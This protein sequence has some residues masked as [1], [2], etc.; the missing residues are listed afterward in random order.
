MSGTLESMRAS[1]PVESSATVPDEVL[2]AEIDRTP[3]VRLRE[4]SEA[5][6]MFKLLGMNRAA[7]HPPSVKLANTPVRPMYKSVQVTVVH[8]DRPTV[9]RPGCVSERKAG[10]EIVIHKSLHIAGYWF[11]EV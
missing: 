10:N 6:G 8:G 3:M 2:V 9:F 7:S 11:T 1:I 4:S 5:N